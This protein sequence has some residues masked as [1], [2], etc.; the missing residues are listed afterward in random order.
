[1][2]DYLFLNQG[3]LNIAVQHVQFKIKRKII[4]AD[5][6][7]T[8]EIA[9][10]NISEEEFI[11]QLS[12]IGLE[13][14]LPR[15]EEIAIY[16]LNQRRVFIEIINE[17]K[18][19]MKLWGKQHFEDQSRWLGILTEEVGEVAE[20]VNETVLKN[21]NKRHKGGLENIRKELIQVAAVAVAAVEDINDIL[22][23]EA[24][25]KENK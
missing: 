7:I 22:Y 3:A 5:E 6:P 20:A 10:L 24:Y 18:R 15:K 13:L 16:S 21:A 11:K 17:R 1:M 2:D 4:M 14:S 23:D 12:E 25:C 9:K 19:Q 8:T